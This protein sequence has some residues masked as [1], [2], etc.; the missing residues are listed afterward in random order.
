MDSGD[1]EKLRLY[2]CY[3]EDSGSTAL[4]E[5]SPSALRRIVNVSTGLSEQ[6]EKRHEG[7]ALRRRFV[8]SL[9]RVTAP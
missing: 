9:I 1:A 8:M 2:V 7:V 3:Q 4:L 5:Q 6:A